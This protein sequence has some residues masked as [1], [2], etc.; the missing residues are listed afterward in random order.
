M[1][2]LDMAMKQGR[3]KALLDAKYVVVKVD[4]ARFDSP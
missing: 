2:V 4:V 1:R 3:L